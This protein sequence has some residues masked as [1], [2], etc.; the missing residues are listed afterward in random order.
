MSQI[1]YLCA[2][3]TPPPT[4]SKVF[5]YDFKMSFFSQRILTTISHLQLWFKKQLGLT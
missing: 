5:H 3:F 2:Y 4:F 1:L